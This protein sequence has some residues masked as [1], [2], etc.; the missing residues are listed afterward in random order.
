MQ[1]DI[2]TIFVT[3]VLVSAMAGLF[4]W[5]QFHYNREIPG[6]AAAAIGDGCLAVGYLLIAL[7]GSISEVVSLVV[8][9]ALVFIGYGLFVV[10]ARQFFHMKV[11]GL[12]LGL[13]L[14]AYVVEFAYFSYIVPSVLVRLLVYL[15]VYGG[16]MAYVLHLLYRKYGLLRSRTCLVAS[17]FL[18]LSAL[19]S[20][21]CA[22]MSL[23]AGGAHDILSQRTANALVLLEQLVFVVGWAFSFSLMVNQ[24]VYDE[25]LKADRDLVEYAEALALSN[26]DLE[27]FSIAISH[28]LQEPLRTVSSFVQLLERRYGAQMGPEAGEFIGYVVDG[29]HRMKALILD[30]LSYARVQG[31]EAE[32]EAV[33][34]GAIYAEAVAMLDARIGATGATVTAQP[35]PMVKGNRALLVSLLQNLIGNALKYQ[36]EIQTPD[37]RVSAQPSGEF[38]EIAVADNGIGIDPQY[39]DRI[40]EVFRRLHP[41]DRYGGTGVGLAL[42]RRIVERHGGRIWVDSRVGQGATFRFTLPAAI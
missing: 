19:G 25:K 41:L 39:H 31:A 13:A 8:A 21:V 34:L 3:L 32:F 40:F 4:L 1:F 36:P 12:Y 18:A 10:S 16:M 9:N 17:G 2:P 23:Q 14:A 29:V 42:C 26:R 27:Q 28:D 35:L 22:V 37:I 30:M 5:L 33:D 38:W 24:R 20:V 7:R 11:R 6:L 15:A